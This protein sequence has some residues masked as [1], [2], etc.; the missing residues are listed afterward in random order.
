VVLED[1]GRLI[2][3]CG[4]GPSV[5]NRRKLEGNHLQRKTERKQSDII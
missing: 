2:S 3:F 5:K 4:F 1:G